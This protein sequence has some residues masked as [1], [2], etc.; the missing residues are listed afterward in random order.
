M[1]PEVDFRLGVS[2]A[3]KITPTREKILIEDLADILVPIVRSG[4]IDQVDSVVI[5]VGIALDIMKGYA[6]EAIRARDAMALVDS[7]AVGIMRFDGV[8]FDSTRGRYVYRDGA[9]IRL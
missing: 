6:R 3:I 1:L 8:Y 2:E 9:L 5:Y 4:T 7:A